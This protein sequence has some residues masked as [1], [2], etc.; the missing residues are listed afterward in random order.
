TEII[1]A[2]PQTGNDAAR[3]LRSGQLLINEQEPATIADG[4]RVLS[5]GK[6]NY[7]ILIAVSSDGSY[8]KDV[9]PH[10]NIDHYT[11]EKQQGQLI[12]DQGLTD[13]IEVPDAMIV[14]A[15]QAYFLR[16]NL[17]VEPT[18]ALALGALFVRPE[19]FVG[20]RVCCIVSGG[21]VDPAVYSNILQEVM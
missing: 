19:R 10:P 9:Q 1:G 11:E 5:L 7:E 2:E 4:A 6:L 8:Q 17:K 12:V 16:A 20:K 18:G 15:L 3:S 21:N 13:I 14:K